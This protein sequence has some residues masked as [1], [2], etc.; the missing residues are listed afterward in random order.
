MVVYDPHLVKKATYK[1]SGDSSVPD[2]DVTLSTFTAAS[3]GEDVGFAYNQYF[4]EKAYSCGGCQASNDTRKVMVDGTQYVYAKDASD[5]FITV[6]KESG[7]TYQQ[8]KQSTVFIVLG[9][10]E[11]ST[12]S[13]VSPF[14]DLEAYNGMMIPWYDLNSN[15]QAND[16]KFLDKF[17]FIGES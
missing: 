17:N 6:Q 3:F 7:F 8:K 9:G 12:P 13:K 16:N 5:N 10:T 2:S 4:M 15:M 11:T 14:P 1:H